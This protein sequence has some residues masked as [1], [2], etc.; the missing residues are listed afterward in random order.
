VADASGLGEVLFEF[1]AI[2]HSV[3]VVAIHAASGVEVSVMGPA[4]AARVDLERLALQKL[5]V[6]LCSGSGK[7][8]GA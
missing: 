7:P 3:K 4:S 8:G 1:T 6:R 2:G 5:A